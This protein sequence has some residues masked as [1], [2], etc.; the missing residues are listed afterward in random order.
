MPR[1]FTPEDFKFVIEDH[2][3]KLWVFSY[4]ED[5]IYSEDIIEIS[6]NV[7]KTEQDAYNIFYLLL[8]HGNGGYDAGIKIGRKELQKEI[9]ELL[10]L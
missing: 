9:K 1:R 10:C 2:E 5:P 6:F 8:L 3:H 4:T 7:A